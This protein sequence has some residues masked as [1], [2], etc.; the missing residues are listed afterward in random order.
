VYIENPN[1]VQIPVSLDQVD[2]VKVNIG[3]KATIIFDAY[4]TLKVE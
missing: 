2:I 1:G 3:K 4:P